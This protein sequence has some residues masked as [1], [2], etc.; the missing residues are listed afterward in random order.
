M[1]H[2]VVKEG[3]L[4]GAMPF[5]GECIQMLEAIAHDKT[6]LTP[7]QMTDQLR[8][9]ASSLVLLAEHFNLATQSSRRTVE[10]RN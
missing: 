10:I 6:A 9:V 1:P 5:P 8:F 7:E 4:T 3:G 2:V